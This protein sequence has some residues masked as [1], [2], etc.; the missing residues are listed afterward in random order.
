MNTTSFIVKPS[1]IRLGRPDGTCFYC[2][3]ELGKEHAIGCVI[4]KRT[5]I[6]Q[7]TFD[8][9]LEVPENWNEYD[10]EFWMNEGSSCA[11]NLHADIGRQINRMHGQH[12][13]MCGLTHGKFIR[14]ATEQDEAKYTLPLND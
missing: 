2:R 1:D 14:E 11:N 10:I 7:V 12:Y 13:C 6:V 8:L 9:L 4:R 3:A 5:I